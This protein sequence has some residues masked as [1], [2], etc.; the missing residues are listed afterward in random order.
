[1]R[2]LF[3]VLMFLSAATHSACGPSQD[4]GL[5]DKWMVVDEPGNP[6]GKA[7]YSPGA[8]PAELQMRAKPMDGPPTVLNAT[9]RK[10]ECPNGKSCGTDC[11]GTISSEGVMT[12][13]CK[14]VRCC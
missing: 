5:I 12:V 1:M 8:L 13:S 3:L 14:T 11:T 10:F 6:A 9:E 7:F 4:P 2:Y